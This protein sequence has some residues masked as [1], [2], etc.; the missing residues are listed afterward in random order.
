MRVKGNGVVPAE[1]S[2]EEMKAKLEAL[3]AVNDVTA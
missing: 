2:A 3:E 1:Q